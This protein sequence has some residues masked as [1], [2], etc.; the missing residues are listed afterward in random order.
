MRVLAIIACFL[1]AVAVSFV[2]IGGFDTGKSAAG[3]NEAPTSGAA[4]P[5]T[6]DSNAPASSTKR[7]ASVEYMVPCPQ[8]KK[9]K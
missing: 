6:R 9:R 7:G 5:E 8:C 4:T 3:D 1:V 2:L